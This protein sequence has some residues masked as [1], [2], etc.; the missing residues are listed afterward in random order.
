[1][2]P[3]LICFLQALSIHYCQSTCMS[4]CTC[5]YV[6]ILRLNTGISETKG[7]SGLF[8]VGPKKVSKDSWMV[9]LPMTSLTRWRHSDGV[10]SFKLFLPLAFWS[11]L[12]ILTQW[13]PIC[14]LS[15]GSTWIVDPGVLRWLHGL[16]I[17]ALNISKTKRDRGL[18]SIEDV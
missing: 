15:T 5:M 4:V 7:E 9:I 2:S 13:S 16:V 6:R 8:P 11:E 1:M 17:F 12:D 18:I 14:C 3:R 10:I